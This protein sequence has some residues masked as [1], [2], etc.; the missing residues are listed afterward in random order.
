M[1]SVA[2]VGS[3]VAGCCSL[4][5]MGCGSSEPPP[6][7]APLSVSVPS[8][9][10]L[11]TPTGAPSRP[12]IPGLPADTRVVFHASRAFLVTD[13][14]L[15][16]A[17]S[18]CAKGA[19]E[20][21]TDLWAAIDAAGEV[22][23]EV[24][25]S[26]LDERTS[27]C[28]RELATTF[29]ETFRQSTEGLR[30][31]ATATYVRVDTPGFPTG[32]GAGGEGFWGVD[33]SSPVC[34]SFTGRDGGLAIRADGQGNGNIAINVDDPAAAPPVAARVR[35]LFGSEASRVEIHGRMIEV[36]LRQ[37][38]G[39]E[40]AL[41]LRKQ[42]ET[43][44]VP[45]S[46]MSPAIELGDHVVVDKTPAPVERGDIVVFPSPENPEHLF[47]KRVIAV[48][49][50]TVAFDGL[51]PVVNGKPLAACNFVTKRREGE[52][53]TESVVLFLE[54][55]GTRDYLV[56]QQERAAFGMDCAG[57]C[58][59]KKPLRVPEG[60]LFV[61]GDAR[62]RSHDSRSFKGSATVPLA[63]VVGRP[64]LV[65][66]AVG[67]TGVRFDRMGID[68]NALPPFTTPNEILSQTRC[69]AA[70]GRAP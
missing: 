19:L 45:S 38:P 15:S 56:E 28:A 54:R 53:G 49:G 9:A 46:S 60:H 32:P 5:S 33:L 36:H 55:S 69:E 52:N 29:L 10:S 51:T 40:L 50:D 70:L 37:P 65:A 30:V 47:I 68:P 42:I 8:V 17:Q 59:V 31:T 41:A 58:T 20:G 35:A 7:T 13:D 16:R 62:D 61:V 24:H 26:A 39:L 63:S 64:V 12:F 25:G 1:R 23:I 6:A 2:F 21:M 4:L 44:K 3:L 67:P 27:R 48:G 43:F 57:R 14:V 18:R 66:F 34:L 22:R 11:R